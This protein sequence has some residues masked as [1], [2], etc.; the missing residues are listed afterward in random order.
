MPKYFAKEALEKLK[1][2]LNHLQTVKRKEIA[3]KIK[4][5]AGFG[6][7]KENAAYQEAKDAQAFLEKEISELRTTVGQARIVEKKDNGNVQI[8]SV[9]LVESEGNQEK[10]EI[11]EPELANP[12]KGIIS[13]K[14]PLGQRLLGK[15]KGDKVKLANNIEYKIIT[16]E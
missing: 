16:I 15:K 6:D 11:V 13:H 10:F 12:M 9:V 7:F 14:S 1:K 3:D 8:G 4:H 5:A 2:K